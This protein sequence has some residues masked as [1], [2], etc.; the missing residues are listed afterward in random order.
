MDQ[1]QSILRECNLL[2][3]DCFPD[4]IKQIG[5]SGDAEYSTDQ[6]RLSFTQFKNIVLN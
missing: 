3:T 1:C 4:Q 5:G 6:V 2:L